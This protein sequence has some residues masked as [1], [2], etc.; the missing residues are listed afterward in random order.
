MKSLKGKRRRENNDVSLLVLEAF[1]IVPV[2][3]GN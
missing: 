2:G 1:S 3:I